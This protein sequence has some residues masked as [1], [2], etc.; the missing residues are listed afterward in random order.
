MKDAYPDFGIGIFHNKLSDRQLSAMRLFCYK[1]KER[2]DFSLVESLANIKAL[3][4]IHITLFCN[5]YLNL[6][7]S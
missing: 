4:L 3:H 2:A 5:L 7:I 1:F 6:N